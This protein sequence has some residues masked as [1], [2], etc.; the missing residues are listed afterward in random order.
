MPPTK[1]PAPQPTPVPAVEEVLATDENDVTPKQH[2]DELKRQLNEQI[3][4]SI[5]H[6]NQAAG[7]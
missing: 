7:R 5:A 2:L 4:K 6:Q 1:K 3:T